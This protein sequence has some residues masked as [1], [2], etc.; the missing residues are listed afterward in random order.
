MTNQE[1]IKM[2]RSYLQE[3]RNYS[4]NTV[5]A[6]TEDI[7]TL[8]AFLK[9]EDLGSLYLVSD[10]IARFYVSFL[11]GN[12]SPTSIR[13]KISSV[14]SMYQMLVRDHSL[15]TNPFMNVVLPK[16]KKSLPKF[17]YENEM[18]DFLKNIDLSTPLGIRNIAIFEMLYGSGLRVSEL[19]AIKINDLDFYNKTILVHG[20]GA[21]DR[22]V[23]I[24]DLSISKMKTYLEQVRPLFRARST[25]AESY[26][27]FVNFK[28]GRLT[29]RGVRDI[30]DRE[31]DR[32]SST[33]KMSPHAFRHS[34]AT[35]L[36]NHGVDLRSVQELLGHSSLATT[37]IYTK[38]SKEKL[39]DIYMKTH[40][41]AKIK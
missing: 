30:L 28:G 37:Q 26:S 39:K 33:L 21:K 10:R 18:N 13:R 25:E 27:L 34:F 36:L 6:Y 20:K 9:N 1:I 23:P 16:E 35:H 19:V 22:Y 41:R 2:Y 31:L 11:H 29:S 3:T 38:V 14:R 5:T 4:P 7:Q 40:P 17:V 15:K 12:Y 8:E 32:Q 24:H